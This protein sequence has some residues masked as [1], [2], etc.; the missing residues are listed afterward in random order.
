VQKKNDEQ[1]NDSSSFG[2]FD[3]GLCGAAKVH[4][5]A[6]PD[7][8]LPRP[9]RA[10]AGRYL[11]WAAI[12]MT[13]CLPQERLAFAVANASGKGLTAALMIT[14]VQSSLRT[15]AAFAGN[16][17]AAVMGAVNREVHASSLADR[18]ATLFPWGV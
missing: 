12:A 2:R 17:G 6:G 15:A 14:N 8:G 7:I 13:F 3:G 16:D 18:F 10:V 9:L 4:A 1:G 11:S 5:C